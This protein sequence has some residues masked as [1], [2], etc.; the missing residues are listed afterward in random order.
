ML[1][2]V[3]SLDDLNALL[4]DWYVKGPTMEYHAGYPGTTGRT[5]IERKWD[6]EVDAPKRASR[7]AKN[8]GKGTSQK[9][10]AVRKPR[11]PLASIRSIA[12]SSRQHPITDPRLS[13]PAILRSNAPSLQ[14]LTPNATFEPPQ[15]PQTRVYWDR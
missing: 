5:I 13:T 2:S 12:D 1:G 14:L 10:A 15:H 6:E 4:R 8:S 9:K 7:K 11:G 3:T